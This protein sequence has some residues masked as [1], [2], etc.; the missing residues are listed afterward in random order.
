MPVLIGVLLFA[1]VSLVAYELLRPRSNTIVRRIREAVDGTASAAERTH[2]SAVSRVAGP[3]VA[4]WGRRISRVLP[5][6]LV[7]SVDRMLVMSDQPWSLP[8]FL[9]AWAASILVSVLFFYGVVTRTVDLTALQ[10]LV[11]AA[12]F[13]PAG[14][15]LPYAYLRSK[16]MRR[17]KAIVRALPD[18]MD[19]LVTTVEAGLG[20][21]AAFAL[22]AEKTTGPLADVLSGYLRAI[23]FGRSRRQAL[24]DVAER[25]GVQQLMGIAH[26]VN[27]AEQLGSTVGDVLRVYADDLRVARRQRAE[28]AAQ[29]APV[30]MT[31]P[32]VTCFLP[33]IAAVV[34]VP[35]ILNMAKFIGGVGAP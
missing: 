31:I 2:G 11:W 25:A 19:L 29:R 10:T 30:L 4:R 3:F 21:D 12:L 32:L 9:F 7:R 17:Q 20:V 14:G 18:A 35:S 27:Q 22:V 16:V 33:A 6:N 1:S 8:A 15:L 5:P 28:S 34:L 26:A 24:Q 13:L 23:G